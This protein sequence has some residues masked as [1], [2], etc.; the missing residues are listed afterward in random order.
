MNH[1]HQQ[2]IDIH[3]LDIPD[4][5]RAFL[6]TEGLSI[7]ARNGHKERMLM[8]ADSQSARTASNRS[9]IPLLISE[10]VPAERACLVPLL[11]LAL[12]LWDHAA[13][14][15]GE[16]A[17][18]TEGCRHSD[19][20][21]LV[22]QWRGALRVI[23]LSD[24][25]DPVDEGGATEIVPISSPEAARELLLE[26]LGGAP[27]VAMV[28]FGGRSEILDLLLETIPQWGRLILAGS[29]MQLTTLDFYNNVHRKC[30]TLSSFLFE[31]QALFYETGKYAVY[32]RNALQILSSDEMAL[33]C[34]RAA[35]LVS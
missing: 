26:K 31:S 25:C 7:G 12:S 14:E 23:R 13:L 27:G 24:R 28:D 1:P 29:K 32:V 6:A 30:I 19:L 11:T 35:G 2:S 20:I 8:V 10:N 22:A 4:H 17:V 9:P 33:A 16:T 18:F 5:Y 34:E 15:I 21:A 3:P